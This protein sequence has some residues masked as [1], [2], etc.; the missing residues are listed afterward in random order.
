MIVRNEAQFLTRCLDSLG[1]IYDELCVVDTG[2]ADRTVEIAHERHA[3]VTSFVACNDAEGRIMDFAMARNV[4]LDLASGDWIL[5]IDADEVLEA[6]ARRIRKVIERKNAG[7]FGVTMR[8][9][10]ATWISGRLFRRGP[11]VRYRGRIHEYASVQKEFVVE[12]SIVIVN[13]PDKT[14]KEPSAIRNIRLCY[15]AIQEDPEDARLFHFLGNEMQKAARIKEAITYYAEALR[16]GSFKAGL[17]HTT[18]YL[19]ICYL[20]EDRFEEGLE[21]AFRALRI[22]PRFAEAHC[23]IAD[24]YSLQGRPL[25]ARSWYRSAL[26]CKRPPAENVFAAQHWCYNEYPKRRIRAIDA[27]RQLLANPESMH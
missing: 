1:D 12:P 22:D 16:L 7:C 15:A 13:R 19:G 21:L 24:L 6:G 8:S 20:L 10:G 11:T 27:E 3:K 14:G 26:T 2:S 23:L 17:F 25:H 18:Y 9:N 4:A 5:Q